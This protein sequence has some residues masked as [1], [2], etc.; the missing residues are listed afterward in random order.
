[1]PNSDIVTEINKMCHTEQNSSKM[2]F[3]EFLN[4]KKISEKYQLC[5]NQ[6]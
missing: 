5:N 6:K 3:D 1:M 4:Q 2:S